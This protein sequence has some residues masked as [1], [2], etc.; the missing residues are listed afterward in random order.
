LLI[1]GKICIIDADWLLNKQPHLLASLTAYCTACETISN[2]LIILILGCSYAGVLGPKLNRL[3]CQ[4]QA[5]R[6]PLR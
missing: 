2:E 6:R 5:L 3:R 1:A 4:Q